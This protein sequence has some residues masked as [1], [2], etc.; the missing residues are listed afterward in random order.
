MKV[1]E[2]RKAKNALVKMLIS[3]GICVEVREHFWP[4]DEA[5]RILKEAGYI[6]HITAFIYQNL[7]KHIPILLKNK[8]YQRR[9][10]SKYWFWIKGDDK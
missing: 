10:G 2:A 8:Y 4:Y 3:K 9:R 5:R 1:N 6:A 7:E